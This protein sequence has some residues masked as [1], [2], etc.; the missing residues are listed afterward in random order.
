MRFEK[1][2]HMYI[3]RRSLVWLQRWRKSLGF[4]VQSP[5]VYGF[6]RNVVNEHYPYYAYETLQK[7]LPDI[8]KRTRKLCRLYFRIA[9]W[10][11][12]GTIVEFAPVTRVF[13]QYMKTGYHGSEILSV[14]ALQNE[15][16]YSE[17][18]RK[19]GKIEI[20]C[21]EP[22]E[23]YLTFFK[24]AKGFVDDSSMFI[25]HHIKRDRHTKIF[26]KQIVEDTDCITTL[27]LYYC[28]IVFF[29]SKRYKEHYIFNF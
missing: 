19:I 3:L 11:Q 16:S 5:W 17:E 15:E 22:A 13:A 27:D 8:D 2:K 28:G 14:D 10:K 25:I 23:D 20:L 7:Q 4:G 12:A 6:N 21:I 9:N 26:W 1:K 24:V 29:D 18:L